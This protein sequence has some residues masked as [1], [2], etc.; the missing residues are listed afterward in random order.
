MEIKPGY[1]V[2]AKS[3]ILLLFTC[4]IPVAKRID[5]KKK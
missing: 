5:Q 3:G 1:A 2:R 4:Q